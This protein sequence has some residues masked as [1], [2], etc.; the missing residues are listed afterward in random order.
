MIG[1][2]AEKLPSLLYA[3]LNGVPDDPMESD[4]GYLPPFG[5]EL[6]RTLGRIGWLHRDNWIDPSFPPT[7]FQLLDLLYR[8]QIT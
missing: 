2:M 3:E 1:A 4:D 5:E 7:P 6:E 8:R